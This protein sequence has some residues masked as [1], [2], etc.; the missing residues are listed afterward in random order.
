ML[1]RS[2]ARQGR[3]HGA[4]EALG[5]RLLADGVPA[6]PIL[7]IEAVASSEHAKFRQMVVRQDDYVGPGIPI[8][9]SDTPASIRRPPPALGNLSTK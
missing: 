3:D 6:A 5:E 1:F 4:G 9:L 8:K 2:L 7:D